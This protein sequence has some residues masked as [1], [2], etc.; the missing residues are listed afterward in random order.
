[1]GPF[2]DMIIAFV[3]VDDDGV[4]LD[5]SVLDAEILEDTPL[6]KELAREDFRY[7]RLLV[8]NAY[9][10]ETEDLAIT[11]RVEYYD[12]ESG[13]F[14]PNTDDSCTVI[15]ASQLTLLEGTETGELQPEETS[16]VAPQSS[17]FH[18]GQIQG[19]Q[20]ALN[21]TDDTFT[22]TAPG[23]DNHGTIDVELDLGQDG[24]N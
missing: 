21:P 6:Y 13:R 7:G 17:T 20:A 23:L 11:F 9:G 1:D 19:V 24:L 15:N 8:D 12:S 14:V 16:I 3:P 22:A 18:N 10:P 4:T 5:V 2:E